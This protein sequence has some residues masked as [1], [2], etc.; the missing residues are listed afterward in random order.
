MWDRF[1]ASCA[2]AQVIQV[3]SAFYGRIKGSKCMANNYGY[4]GCSTDVKVKSIFI[5]KNCTGHLWRIEKSSFK[6]WNYD[7]AGC[8]SDDKVSVKQTY[9][10]TYGLTWQRFVQKKV[11]GQFLW[12]GRLLHRCQSECQIYLSFIFNNYG[13][14]LK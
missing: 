8:V 3:T 13:D 4:A 7:Y 2:H 14:P 5:F 12:L 1:E 10:S 6:Q 11:H 9:I